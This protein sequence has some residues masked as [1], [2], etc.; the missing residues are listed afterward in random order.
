VKLPH[1]Q[2]LPLLA[3]ALGVATGPA[4]AADEQPIVMK[5]S[6][7]TLNDIQHEW[8]KEFVA[9]VEKDSGGRIKG[10]IYPA[11]Q[12]G[13]IPR[14]IEGTQFGSI[15]GWVGPPEFLVGV[16][17]RYEVM[18][19]PGIVTGMENGQRI[20]ADPTIQSMML[21]FGI[22]KGLHG[23][24]FFASQPSCIIERTPIRHLADFK[25][26]KIR[27]L[28]S[29]FQEELI[30]RFGGTPVAMTLADVLPALQQGAIDGAVGAVPVFTTL[31]YFD[32]AKFITETGQ[33]FIFTI[34]V[35]SK[36]WY[37]GLPADLRKIIDDDGARTGP[38]AELWQ[39]DFYAK[40]RKLWVEKGDELIA[41]PPEE[42]ATMMKTLASVGDDV[43]KSKPALNEAY[44]TLVAAANRNK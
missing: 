22:D 14:Q 31:Q 32:A 19:A 8:I 24:G 13:T 18:S 34:A 26:R 3:L 2:F 15:Q 41:L 12:L 17:A 44:K 16:D 10:E 40:Q 6:T 1:R 43:S 4:F 20:A 35:L 5:M 28:A 9:A 39:G 33:P 29:Q 42:Q 7:A 27:V 30:S 23:V 11:S 21:G 36:S 38:A 25:G 37:D